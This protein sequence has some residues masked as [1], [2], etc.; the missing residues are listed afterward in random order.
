[1]GDSMGQDLAAS[2]QKQ[3]RA[4]LL[5]LALVVGIV[6]VGAADRPSAAGPSAEVPECADGT[7]ARA[8]ELPSGE[9]EGFC[10]A[11]TSEAVLASISLRKTVGTDESTCAA[12]TEISVVADT[13]VFYCYSVV[14]DGTATMTVHDLDDD[15]LGTLLDG[16][17]YTLAPGASTFVTRS[18]I[19]ASA[20]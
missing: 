10:G 7:P 18:A 4:W 15:Q 1:M 19:I 14:N 13:E 5:L 20:P 2:D 12:D 17:E 6:W 3:E 8:V 16:F 11:A 9:V